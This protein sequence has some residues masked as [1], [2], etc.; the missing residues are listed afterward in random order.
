MLKGKIALISGGSRGIGRAIALAFAKAGADIAILYAGNE[1]AAQ[2]TV[3]EAKRN[4]VRAQ[5]YRCDV[6][7]YEA[8]AQVVKKVTED[9]GPIY[10][11][12]NNAGITRDKL[13]AQMSAEDFTTVID[14]NLAGAFNLIRH[15][16]GGFLRQ[17]GGRIINITSVVGLMGNAGQANYA[18]SKAGIIGLTKSVAKELGAR[19]VTCNAIAPGFIQSDMTEAMPQAAKDVLLASIPAKRPG[20]PEDVAG[21]ALFLA[22]EGGA[23]ITGTVL[24]VDG[25]LSM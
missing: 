7:D 17:R 9:L 22:G 13:I 23:Y 5:C 6:G 11:L 2:E 1:Q 14:T 24:P 20:T 25:G 12:V 15:T 21:L 19:G 4:G 16:Y 8:V 18:A 10:A 3:E